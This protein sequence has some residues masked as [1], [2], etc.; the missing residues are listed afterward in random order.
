MVN[1]NA[2]HHSAGDAE[3]LGAIEVWPGLRVEAHERLVDKSSGLESVVGALSTQVEAGEPSELN[4]K[5]VEAICW[6]QQPGGPE[7]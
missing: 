6:D 5:F 4:V 7:E 1:E 3:D 2:A